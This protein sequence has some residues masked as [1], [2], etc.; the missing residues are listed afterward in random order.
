MAQSHKSLAQP[1]ETQWLQSFR[2]KY[3]CDWHL[4]AEYKQ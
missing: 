4:K 3:K 1:E 2:T